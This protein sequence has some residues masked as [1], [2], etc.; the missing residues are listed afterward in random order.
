MS[1][2]M[3]ADAHT[4]MMNDIN[5]RGR[6]IRELKR[7]NA[8]WLEYKNVAEADID[9]MRNILGKELAWNECLKEAK[10]LKEE[11][12][13]LK[14][15]TEFTIAYKYIA[16]VLGYEQEFNDYMA[17]HFNKQPIQD[18]FTE[19][20]GTLKDECNSLKKENEKLKKRGD[21]WMKACS[22]HSENSENNYKELQVENK[23]LKDEIKTLEAWKYEVIQTAEVMDW[24][25]PEEQEDA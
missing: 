5:A 25:L 19:W 13:K 6:E 21:G 3:T 24:D 9:N 7:Q 17:Q 1:V 23:K 10:R 8:T 18:S 20:G 2:T 4:Q 16:N 14:K 11:N 12:E 15:D 22:T